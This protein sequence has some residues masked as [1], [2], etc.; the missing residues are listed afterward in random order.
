[1]VY[2]YDICTIGNLNEGSLRKNRQWNKLYCI[3]L[4]IIFIYGNQEKIFS[5]FYL[6]SPIQLLF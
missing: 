2:L 5:F 1:M 4:H 6:Y 3:G